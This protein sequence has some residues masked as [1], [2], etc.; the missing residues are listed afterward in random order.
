[1]T[2]AKQSRALYWLLVAAGRVHLVSERV[3]RMVAQ[4]VAAFMARVAINRAAA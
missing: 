3:R 1:M 4:A 2:T